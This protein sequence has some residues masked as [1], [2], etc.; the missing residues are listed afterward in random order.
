MSENENV[1]ERPEQ[2]P[3]PEQDATNEPQPC[4]GCGEI[5]EGRPD[6]NAAFERASKVEVRVLRDADEVYVSLGDLGAVVKAAMDL[7]IAGSGAAMEQGA[8]PQI[9]A[10]IDGAVVAMGTNLRS[11]LLDP[12]RYV[13]AKLAVDTIPDEWLDQ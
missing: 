12:N 7:Q 3:E 13:D 9:V 5:H 4:S 6:L 2:Q 1:N 11:I 10:L 8:P